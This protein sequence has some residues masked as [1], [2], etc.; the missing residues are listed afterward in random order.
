M[1]YLI[2]GSLR[3]FPETSFLILR[4]FTG[5]TMCYYHG[6]SKLFSSIERLDKLGSNFT[7]WF[8][9]DS[10]SVPFGIIATFSESIGAL[11]LALGFLTRPTAFLLAF[12]MMVATVK[13]IT[14]VGME[15]TELSLIFLI[16]SCVIFIRGSGRYS[17][18]KLFF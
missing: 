14:G 5:I 17:L 13:N 8:G 3:P 10:L 18:D 15:K 12:T 11:M 7:K 1:K 16:L 6:W 2:F 9:L 4:F